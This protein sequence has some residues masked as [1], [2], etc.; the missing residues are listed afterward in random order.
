MTPTNKWCSLA[1]QRA[2]SWRRSP[3]SDQMLNNIR[4]GRFRGICSTASIRQSRA[5][6]LAGNP[7]TLHWRGHAPFEDQ[8]A[9]CS[10]Q[11]SSGA[12]LKPRGDVARQYL[13]G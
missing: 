9:G 5:L 4:Q 3:C 11:A 7:A 6:S 12:R 13:E 1:Q 2:A 10:E 8:K